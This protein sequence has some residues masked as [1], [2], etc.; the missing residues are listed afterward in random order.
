MLRQA[1]AE[2]N[3]GPRTQAQNALT[4]G[5]WNVTSFYASERG[6]YVVT[7]KREHVSVK[8]TGTVAYQAPCVP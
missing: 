7:G 2:N 4:H 1:F 5:C 3:N 6:G 8:A